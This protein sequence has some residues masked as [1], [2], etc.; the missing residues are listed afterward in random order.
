MATVARPT[1]IPARPHA[2]DV[3]VTLERRTQLLLAWNEEPSTGW[4]PPIDVP[5]I[6]PLYAATNADGNHKSAS[7][8]PA[9]IQT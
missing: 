1:D 8:F 7:I 4:V 9:T 2:F 5:S 6:F 3:A